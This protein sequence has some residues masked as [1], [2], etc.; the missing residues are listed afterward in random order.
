MRDVRI[1]RYPT[2]TS[3]HEPITPVPCLVTDVQRGPRLG[4]AESDEHGTNESGLG[5]VA[6]RFEKPAQSVE[7]DLVRLSAHARRVE[8]V[9]PDTLELGKE[10][11]RDRERVRRCL[12]SIAHRH[13]D[14]R[15]QRAHV[16]ETRDV[17]LLEPTR[18]GGL[19][20]S[21][22]RSLVLL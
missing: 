2:A 14:P 11:G 18:Q 5:G 4:V 15:L 10:V 21:L 7:M 8:G 6:V 3:S 20:N 12:A 9:R 1:K 13:I 16:P 22:G 17:A 19:Q